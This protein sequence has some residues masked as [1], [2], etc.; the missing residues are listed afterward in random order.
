[1][2]IILLNIDLVILAWR[3]LGFLYVREVVIVSRK[4]NPKVDKA[5]KLFKQ[6]E[7]LKDI[8]EMLK[9]PEGTIRRWKSTYNWEEEY[10]NAETERKLKTERSET[11]KANVSEDVKLVLENGELSDRE[12]AFC[13]HFIRCFNATKAYQKAYGC[14]YNTAKAHGYKLLQNVDVEQEIRRLKEA[15]F[16]RQLLDEHDIFQ[17]YLDIAF[18]DMTD[19]ATFG[20]EEIPVIGMYG[21]IE[22]K[23]P[24]T[25][26][27]ELLMQKVNTV[28][29]HEA[30]DVDGT[31]I[32]EV[33]QGKDGAKIKLL[34]KMKAL[35]WLSN[36]MDFATEEQRA[37]IE[38]LK[39]E[40]ARIKG[41]HGGDD[42][43]DDGF[44]EAMRAEAPAIWSSE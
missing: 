28:R 14:S 7:K 31:L 8:A 44:I 17:K 20:Q 40:T 11:K 12:Q 3:K 10:P 41:E 35:E 19:Y 15:R 4:R 42:K 18:S 13:L 5:E 38:K 27:K 29:F 9:L 32:A 36:H 33:S 37:K 30:S 21:P 2:Q 1:M 43:E 34:D 26:E 22:V 23:N 25:N 6:G 24:K 39:A 16:N